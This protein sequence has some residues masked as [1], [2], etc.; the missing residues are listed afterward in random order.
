A[1]VHDPNNELLLEQS[2]Q[3]EASRANWQRAFKLADRLVATQRNHRMA[4]LALALDE[5]KDG[6]YDKSEA[7][8]KRS[9]SGPIGALTSALALAWVKYARGDVKGALAQLDM[10]KQAEWAQFFLRYHRALI[11]DL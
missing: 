2:F 5:F 9:G 4:L 6:N 11:A 3:L 10:P 8:L 7:Y 1:L